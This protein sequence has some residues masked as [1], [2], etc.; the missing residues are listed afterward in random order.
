VRVLPNKWFLN[1]TVIFT[2][3]FFKVWLRAL[4]QLRFK[5]IQAKYKIPTVFET[6]VFLIFQMLLYLNLISEL[7]DSNAKQLISFYSISPQ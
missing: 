2:L 4:I 3:L 6:H 5:K 7:L 1:K